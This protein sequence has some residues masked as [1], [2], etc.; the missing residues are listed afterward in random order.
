MRCIQECKCWK[1]K[2]EIGDWLRNPGVCL[3]W[4]ITCSRLH[5]PMSNFVNIETN[6]SMFLRVTVSVSIIN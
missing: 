1:H 5:I 4:L 6:I 2:T 3:G